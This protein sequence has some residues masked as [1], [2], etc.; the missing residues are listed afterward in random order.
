MTVAPQYLTLKFAPVSVEQGKD[1][2]LAV[3]VD[4]AVDFPGEAKV[5]LVGLPNRVT[6]EPATITKD[7]TEVVF[8]LKTD[9]ASPVGETKSLFCQVVIVRDGEPIVHNLGTGRLRVDAPLPP[10]K[11]AAAKPGATPAVASATSKVE[12]APARPLSRLDKLRMES[13]ERT[14]A[15][16]EGP[17]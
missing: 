16:A 4:K 15:A 13:K 9:P 7:S 17:K 10:K 8:H 3:K 14:R 11:N 5:T 6:T 2:D 1:V 12:E